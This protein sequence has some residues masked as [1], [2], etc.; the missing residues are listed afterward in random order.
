MKNKE[1]TECD[2][3]L[4][5]N[6]V[7]VILYQT[8]GESPLVLRALADLKSPVIFISI[9]VARS[10]RFQIS[11]IREKY[12]EYRKCSIN[13]RLPLYWL[14][15]ILTCLNA[16][17]LSHTRA[18]TLYL[19]AHTC[20]CPCLHTI[21]KHMYTFHNVHT[22]GGIYAKLMYTGEAFN[23][24]HVMLSPSTGANCSTKQQTAAVII[25]VKHCVFRIM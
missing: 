11:Q 6:L 10:Q 1:I 24:F 3:G 8:L 15:T 23:N 7:N 5:N 25:R 13:E 4:I 22:C 2:I 19:H 16:P 18:H 14:F 12:C 21:Y 9:F 20:F 17:Y